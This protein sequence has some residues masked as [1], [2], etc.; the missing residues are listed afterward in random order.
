[1]NWSSHNASVKTNL[2][3]NDVIISFMKLFADIIVARHVFWKA[4]YVSLSQ[5]AFFPFLQL[6][7][8]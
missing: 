1:M 7:S 3:K 6:Y 2:E 5:L 8:T 4:R